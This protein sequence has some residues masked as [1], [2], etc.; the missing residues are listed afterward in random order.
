MMPS[1]DVSAYHL[2]T[3]NRATC[4]ASTGLGNAE[5]FGFRQSLLQIGTISL[6]V[7]LADGVAL[8]ALLQAMSVAAQAHMAAVID[9]GPNLP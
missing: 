7:R 9:H 2:Q 5:R 6:L 3:R 1:R 4:L 8:P